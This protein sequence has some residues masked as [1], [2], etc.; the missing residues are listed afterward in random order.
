N[1]NVAL[2]KDQISG[3]LEQ[4]DESEGEINPADITLIAG[5]IGELGS[6]EP[7]EADARR[8]AL[9]KRLVYAVRRMTQQE[10]PLFSEDGARIEHWIE[11]VKIYQPSNVPE[12][13]LALTKRYHRP[14]PAFSFADSL[15]ELPDVFE[16]GRVRPKGTGLI[17][18]AAEPADDLGL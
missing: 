16:P 8:Q 11:L 2:L 6:L 3:K 18:G 17:A 9:G 15:S 12:L 13:Q 4:F 7:M 5:K 14:D 1:L 10:R